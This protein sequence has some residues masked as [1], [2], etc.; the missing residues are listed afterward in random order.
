VNTRGGVAMRG[1]TAVVRPVRPWVRKP[2]H[3]TIV[4][5]VALRTVIAATAVWVVPAAPRKQ[6]LLVLERLREN[7]E[8]LGLL[9]QVLALEILGF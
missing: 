6:H 4:S 3:G 7:P 9:F 8:L 5:G 2:Y 1:G